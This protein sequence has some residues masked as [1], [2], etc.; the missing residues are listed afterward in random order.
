MDRMIRNIK[1]YKKINFDR[2]IYEFVYMNYCYL[3]HK[4]KIYLKMSI[5]VKEYKITFY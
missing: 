3:K 4:N 5:L 1:D 2:K